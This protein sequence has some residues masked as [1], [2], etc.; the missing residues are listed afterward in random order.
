MSEQDLRIDIRTVADTKGAD[1]AEKALADVEK[2]AKETAA[3]SQKGFGGQ[4]DSARPSQDAEIIER[5]TTAQEK[6]NDAT[7]DYNATAPKAA[8]TTKTW[9]RDWYE[10]STAAD[11]AGGSLGELGGKIDSARLKQLAAAT[12]HAEAAAAVEKFASVV[13]T[14]GAVIT[15]EFTAIAAAAAWSYDAVS[16]TINGYSDEIAKAKARGVEIAPEF[17][18]EVAAWKAT[19]GPIAG[20]ID[21]IG[22]AWE[23]VKEAVAN[24]VDFFSGLGDFKQWQIDNEAFMARAKSAQAEFLE[25]RY[26]TR[27]TDLTEMY[28]DEARALGQQLSLARQIAEARQQL[29]DV[30]VSRAR[31]AVTRAQQDGGDVGAAEGNVLLVQLQASI[32]KLQ[33]GVAN[34]K[35]EVEQSAE[36]LALAKDQLNL[37]IQSG[38]PTAEIEQL[39]NFVSE[40]ENALEIAQK[41]LE[42]QTALAKEK[43]LDAGEKAENA[44]VDL[45]AKYETAMTEAATKVF[46]DIQAQLTKV[47][48]LNLGASIEQIEQLK[49]QLTTDQKTLQA[50]VSSAAAEGGKAT[51]TAASDIVKSF[52]ELAAN[53]TG[54]LAKLMAAI[55]AQKRESAAQQS[56]INQLFSR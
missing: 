21:A 34:A 54:G 32:R 45:Q 43:A 26:E 17:E 48:E 16:K 11:K 33:D 18:A 53:Y 24:P 22:S 28:E 35:G 42:N 14:K 36:A 49:A 1:Q 38:R 19:L 7:D 37:A 30:A 10:H 39:T 46:D 4:I 6:L 52:T 13:G 2:Q 50:S 9:S 5:T 25:K 15:A 8:E 27:Q 3:A 23:K 44:L 51:A 41:A 56:Q 47:Q 12:G 40:R 31:N 55:D 20:T 29:D